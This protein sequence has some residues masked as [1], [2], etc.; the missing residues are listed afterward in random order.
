MI[1]FKFFLLLATPET[2]NYKFTNLRFFAV[3]RVASREKNFD[4]SGTRVFRK[5]INQEK[6]QSCSGIQKKFTAILSRYCKQKGICTIL[7]EDTLYF[8]FNFCRSVI[9]IKKII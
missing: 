1:F 5:Y 8:Q 4:K 2:K 9:I 3:L 6:I 7:T